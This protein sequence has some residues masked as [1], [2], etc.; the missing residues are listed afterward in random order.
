MLCFDTNFDHI[1]ATIPYHIHLRSLS[2]GA[3]HPAT[4]DPAYVSHRPE[5]A[6]HSFAIQSC[7]DYVGVLFTS[8]DDSRNEL[9]I[10]NWKTGDRKLVSHFTF[11]SSPLLT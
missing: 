4:V 3:T 9:V 7:G 10:W 2:T 6:S 8:L 1:S 5:G 11:S